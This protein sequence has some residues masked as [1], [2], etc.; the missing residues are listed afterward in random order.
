M[1]ASTT[2]FQQT[3]LARVA[4]G[5]LLRAGLDRILLART[6][7]LVVL[8]DA[9]EVLEICTGGFLIEAAFSPQKLFEL[10][11]MDGAI[12]LSANGTRIVRANVHLVPD[13]RLVTT[14]TGT[15]H[16]TAERVASSVDAVV[17]AVSEELSV[18]SV[19]YRNHKQTLQP[20][21]AVLSRASQAL[22]TLERY[23]ERFES[24]LTS[25]VPLE[26]N[27]QVTFRDVLFAL[28]RGEMVR[29]IGAEIEGYL[30]ELGTDGRLLALQS[31]EIS[32]DFEE[33][34][35]SL[36]FDF[37]GYSDPI[38]IEAVRD[39]LASL[40]TDDVTDLRTFA[41]WVARQAI[42]EPL[43]QINVDHQ[44]D[45]SLFTLP[46]R[47]SRILSNISRIPTAAVRV[48]LDRYPTLDAIRSASEQELGALDE[49]GPDW[50]RVI[51]EALGVT[52]IVTPLER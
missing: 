24:V 5:T 37:L 2:E 46:S 3:A 34:F 50:A 43:R 18:I 47:G 12:I 13:P 16:R 21:P 36:I 48:L 11:K 42:C 45:L 39:S 27:G 30:L 29:R 25:L 14:E 9:A 22:S 33:R 7:A 51:R 17:V 10:A 31:A 44:G 1:S 8:G 26:L 4:P 52:P 6:G 20:I 19:Y 38:E 41:G 23:R 35:D 28:Q 40:S 32:L 49:I 15:R